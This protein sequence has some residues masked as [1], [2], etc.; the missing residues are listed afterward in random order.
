MQRYN[1]SKLA[2]ILWTYALARHLGDARSAVTANAFNPG[3]MPGTGLAREYGGLARFLWFYVMPY[4]LPLVRVM[5]PSA[6][7]VEGSGADLAWVALGK[8]T[9]GISGKYFDGRREIMSSAVSY[10]VAKQEDLWQWS[11]KAVL[12]E[13]ADG[14]AGLKK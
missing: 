7:A 2:N 6:R 8:E 1:S 9:A 11:V 13:D 14:L 4:I 5:M 3:L 10:D 12:G